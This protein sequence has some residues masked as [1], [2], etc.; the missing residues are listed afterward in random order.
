MGICISSKKSEGVYFYSDGRLISV[1][2]HS[3]K[4]E[5]RGLV[6]LVNV[7]SNVLEASFCKTKF[8]SSQEENKL[9]NFVKEKLEIYADTIAENCHSSLWWRKFGY[10]KYDDEP[11]SDLTECIKIRI[12][13]LN[14]LAIQ[15]NDCLNWRLLRWVKDFEKGEFPKDNWTCLNWP[16]PNEFLYVRLY[17]NLMNFIFVLLVY[18]LK[19]IDAVKLKI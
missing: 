19:K 3:K 8:C 12:Q 6:T 9:F 17:L 5:H 1:R 2:D 11:S 10:N 18:L 16:D 13:C 15:C 14:G 4:C 7:P